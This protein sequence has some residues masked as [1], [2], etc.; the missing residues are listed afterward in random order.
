[1]NTEEHSQAQAREISMQFIRAI[2]GCPSFSANNAFV[3][4]FGVMAEIDE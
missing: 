4:Q 1:M 2:R 3:F